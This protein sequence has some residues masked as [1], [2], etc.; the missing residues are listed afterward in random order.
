MGK[1]NRVIQGTALIG[2]DARR[3]ELAVD[4]EL[5]KA[6]ELARSRND[7]IECFG[8]LRRKS[9]TS[10]YDGLQQRDL[11][12]VHASDATVEVLRPKMLGPGRASGP[13]PSLRRR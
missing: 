8:R 4:D 5:I 12:V 9:N 7:A 3:I 11:Q 1:R 6:A 10:R 2:E 13:P